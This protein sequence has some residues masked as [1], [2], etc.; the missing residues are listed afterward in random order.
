MW[1]SG[2]PGIMKIPHSSETP[3]KL[4][5]TILNSKSEIYGK[6]CLHDDTRLGNV[7][8]IIVHIVSQV[9]GLDI[10]SV[11]PVFFPAE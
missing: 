11:F 2:V 1:R 3:A 4:G 10:D 8:I 6:P 9:V 7:S 5:K